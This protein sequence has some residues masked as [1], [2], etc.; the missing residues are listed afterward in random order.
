MLRN[1][2]LAKINWP[3]ATDLLTTTFSLQISGIRADMSFQ[4]ELLATG[5]FFRIA[6]L[7][8]DFR[9]SYTRHKRPNKY[10]TQMHT[11]E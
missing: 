11:H 10:F 7:P 9:V 5:K 1:K 2:I 4:W 8:K 3:K 6:T